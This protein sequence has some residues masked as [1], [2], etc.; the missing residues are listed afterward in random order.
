MMPTYITAPI[1]ETIRYVTPHLV[2]IPD[3]VRMRQ[4]GEHTYVQHKDTD[5]PNQ[6]FS[7]EVALTRGLISAEKI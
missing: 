7:L 2:T 4:D 5:K 6:W 1:A 3:D